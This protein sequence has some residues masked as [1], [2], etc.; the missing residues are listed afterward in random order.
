MV[1][2]DEPTEEASPAAGDGGA[3][4]AR[5]GEGGGGVT[6]GKARLIHAWARPVR[7]A[8]SRPLRRGGWG[9]GRLGRAL[10]YQMNLLRMT[11]GS[12]R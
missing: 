10:R 5:G 3:S 9:R 4:S 7:S 8:T 1:R 11:G 12:F 6:S 2:I